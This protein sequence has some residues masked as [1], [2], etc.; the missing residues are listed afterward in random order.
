VN[1]NEAAA[2]IMARAA[3]LNARVSGMNAENQHRLSVGN[4]VAYGEEAFLDAI[5]E[6]QCDHNA[7]WSLIHQ[8]HD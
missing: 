1:H 3:A 5:T 4:S 8:A 6:E 2:V 7:T